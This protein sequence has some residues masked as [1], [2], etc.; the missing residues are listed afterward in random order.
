MDKTMSHIFTAFCTSMV[1]LLVVN[2]TIRL[3]DSPV[4]I[5]AINYAIKTC[6]VNGGLDHLN[7]LINR[8]EF[9]CANGAKFIFPEELLRW[10]K[11]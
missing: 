6:E 11:S 5:D 3:K 4:N 10:A 8:R 2:I 7:R 9:T 1:I